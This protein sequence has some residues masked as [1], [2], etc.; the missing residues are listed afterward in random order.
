MN[1]VNNDLTPYI[2]THYCTCWSHTRMHYLLSHND[3]QVRKCGTLEWFVVATYM[4]IYVTDSAAWAIALL[5]QERECVFAVLHDNQMVR[6]STRVWS[7]STCQSAQSS[8]A[9]HTDSITRWMRHQHNPP[10][11]DRFIEARSPN[12]GC[13]PRILPNVIIT[14][15]R[16]GYAN[17]FIYFD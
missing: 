17:L 10:L 12:V 11:R 1:R 9:S 4:C 16:F 15:T 13:R 14:Q 3:T 6:W 5:L 8:I 7:W 2:R